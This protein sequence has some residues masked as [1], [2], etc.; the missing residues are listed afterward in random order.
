MSLSEG[1]RA[2]ENATIKS[3]HT[4]RATPYEPRGP[5][6]FRPPQWSKYVPW[7]SQKMIKK[8]LFWRKEREGKEK[9]GKKGEKSKEKDTEKEKRQRHG[10]RRDT[11]RKRTLPL[12]RGFPTPLLSWPPFLS[13]T[14]P[15]PAPDH[16]F[17][18]APVPRWINR[19]P[20]LCDLSWSSL[21]ETYIAWLSTNWLNLEWFILLIFILANR[22]SF[23]YFIALCF[24]ESHA[25]G[26]DC[27]DAVRP[28]LTW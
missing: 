3:C 14:P 18:S 12:L 28:P 2:K 22:L 15:H 23:R 6:S 25:V 10:E 8:I 1:W 4:N 13:H 26:S 19:P 7:N 21:L 20:E 17:V 27:V 5:F 24:P 11:E 9:E 16:V